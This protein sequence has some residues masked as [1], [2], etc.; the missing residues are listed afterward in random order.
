MKTYPDRRAGLDAM[1][2]VMET[3]PLKRV[4]RKFNAGRPTKQ[5]V[6]TP[7]GA[8]T[9]AAEQMGRLAR[10][11]EDE[12]VEA[13]VSAAI[14]TR[15]KI[16]GADVNLIEDTAVNEGSL[17][18]ALAELEFCVQRGDRFTVSGLTFI[19][20]AAD[21]TDVIAYTLERTPEGLAALLTKGDEFR[22]SRQV[23]R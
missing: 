4:I 13:S 8:V 17:H 3:S 5:P 2:K 23:R 10:L 9:L 1:E 12:G 6:D 20:E 21:A 14:I 15:H 19:L 16:P 11:L 18:T 7:L 22:V